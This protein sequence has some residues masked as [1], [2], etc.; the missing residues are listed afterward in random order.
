MVATDTLVPAGGGRAW[1][2]SS[3]PVPSNGAADV[4]RRDGAQ[5]PRGSARVPRGPGDPSHAR[6]PPAAA[7]R[8]ARGRGKTNFCTA[9]SLGQTAT[10]FWLRI[11]I[12]VGIALALSPSS[13]KATGPPYCIS[14][15]E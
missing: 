5:P 15:L 10:G 2:G 1:E 11:W 4:A 3:G 9:A 12:I 13:L 6:P 14:P 8:Y 7:E